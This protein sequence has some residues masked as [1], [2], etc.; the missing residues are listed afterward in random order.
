MAR[1]NVGIPPQ[2]LSDQH[3]IAESV[4]I[5]MITGSLRKNGYQIKSPVPEQFNL[6]TGHINFFKPRI[7][8]LRDRLDEVNSELD[9]RGIKN[10]TNILLS[11]FP[12]QYLGSWCP[13]FAE[14]DIIRERVYERLLN[15]IK[16]RSGFHKYYKKPIKNIQEFALRMKNSPLYYV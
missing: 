6:G 3:L 12:E 1:V 8:Y 5:T 10:S 11:S 13:G 4:E 7:I 9:K 2:Y 16:A 14:S 15:P